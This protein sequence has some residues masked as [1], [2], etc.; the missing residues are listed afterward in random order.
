MDGAGVAEGVVA[1]EQSKRAGEHPS[2]AAAPSG[3]SPEITLMPGKLNKG[4]KSGIASPKTAFS[5]P[6]PG[7]TFLLPNSIDDRGKVIRFSVSVH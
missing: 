7:I 3:Y 2:D 1:D 4:D 6:A 5:G